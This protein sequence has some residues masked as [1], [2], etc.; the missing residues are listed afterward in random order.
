M[1]GSFF[2]MLTSGI[3]TGLQFLQ[4]KQNRKHDINMQNR[5]ADIQKEFAQNGI[6]WRVNDANKAGIH[7]LAAM[8]ANVSSGPTMAVGNPSPAPQ[9]GKFDF[10][11]VENQ[12]LQNE[13]L[14]AQIA[15]INGQTLRDTTQTSSPKY[16]SLTDMP[17]QAPSL[18]QANAA[19][20]QSVISGYE[21]NPGNLYSFQK[22]SEGNIFRGP[23]DNLP[24]AYTEGPLSWGL[25]AEMFRP[26]SDKELGRV[27]D[28]LIKS[29][30]LNPQTHDLI[31][32]ISPIGRYIKIQP[33]NEPTYLEDFKSGAKNIY[34]K[35]KNLYNR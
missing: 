26:F 27:A 3:N 20:P 21:P 9:L 30:E 14:R 28:R 4:N 10:L 13:L 22:D 2:N 18:T 25:A 19:A 23:S 1:L 24:D 6:Q 29:G 15:N 33:K 35:L 32:G 31:Q 11:T 7:P 8:G 34:K 17:G 5:S 16:A 12:K